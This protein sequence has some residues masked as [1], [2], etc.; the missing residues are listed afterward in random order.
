MIPFLH[1]CVLQVHGDVAA[2]H[3]ESIIDI[4]RRLFK[5]TEVCPVYV[6]RAAQRF[7]LLYAKTEIPV[8]RFYHDSFF[9]LFSIHDNYSLVRLFSFNLLC[10]G[11]RFHEGLLERVAIYIWT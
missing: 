2:T 4:Q 7:T 6:A 9:H 11:G 10:A 5:I 8:S 1:V 3:R